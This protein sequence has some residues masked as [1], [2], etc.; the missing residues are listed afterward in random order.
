MVSLH[1]RRRIAG[2]PVGDLR[3]HSIGWRAANQ[4]EIDV[5]GPARGLLVALGL[6]ILLWLVMGG[7]LI[8]SIEILAQ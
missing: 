8:W 4:D 5:F 1:R 3:R 2:T 7:L 6:A